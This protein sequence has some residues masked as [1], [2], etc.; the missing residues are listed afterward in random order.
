MAE[1]NVSYWNKTAKKLGCAPLRKS[2]TTDVLVIGGGITGITCAYCLAQ[3]GI[4][5]ILIETEGICGGTTGNTTGKVTIQHNILYSNLIKKYGQDAAKQYARSQSDALD[6]V[7]TQVNTLSI[8]CQLTENTSY[9]YAHT[10][11]DLAAVERE[12]QAALQLGIEAELVRKPDF[13][14]PNCGMVGFRRQAVFHPVRYLYTL[15]HCAAVM[16][17]GIYCDTKAV[18][19]EPGDV[20]TVYCEHDIVVR[21]K[22]VVMATQYP[23]YDGPNLFFTRLYAKR[24]YGIAVKPER[25]WPEGSFINVSSPARSVRSHTENGERIL[26]VVGES[27]VTG[28]GEPNMERHY[29][30]LTEFA[31]SI[32]GE[33]RVLARWSAQDYETPDQ[34]PYIGRVS[35]GSNL[36]AAAGFGK[37]GLSGGTLAGSMISDLIATGSCPYEGLYSRT[38]GDFLSSPGKAGKEILTPV[39]EL[40]KSK[41]EDT[42]PLTGLQQGQGRVIR[43]EGK[44]AGIYR[45]YDDHVTILDI[46][47]THMTTGLNFNPAEHTWDCPA[48]G[49]RFSAQGRLLEGP[50]KHNLRVLFEGSFSELAQR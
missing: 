5:P 1:S 37:W 45:G 32:A 49:G 15:A 9:V 26:I 11:E 34:I 24:A 25:D 22:H 23:F 28:R 43:F 14:V 41:L 31:R 17:A 10:P 16:G 44:R 42:E 13:P 3:K 4:R 2:C 6:F 46:S 30:A 35:D 50:P 7:R 36:Y 38:R 8:D 27:H 33:P 18:R 20:N 40:I 29:E 47:C 19:L 48:H 39:W 21:A 12:W